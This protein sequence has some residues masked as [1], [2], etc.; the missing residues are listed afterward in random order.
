MTL[1]AIQ[2]ISA[3]NKNLIKLPSVPVPPCGI[4]GRFWQFVLPPDELQSRIPGNLPRPSTVTAVSYLPSC[5]HTKTERQLN[6]IMR[7]GIC[8]VHPSSWM[9]GWYLSNQKWVSYLFGLVREEKRGSRYTKT[10]V[11]YGRSGDDGKSGRG[12]ETWW[13][14]LLQ[15]RRTAWLLAVFGFSSVG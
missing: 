13:F 4:N 7:P 1:Y 2:K 8:C 11:A 10:D 14:S 5:G 12:R 3:L 9:C 6:E 15:S